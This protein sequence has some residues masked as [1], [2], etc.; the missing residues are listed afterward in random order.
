LFSEEIFVFTPKG[1]IKKLPKDATALDF[2]FEIHTEVGS[3]CIG[4]KVNSKLVPLSHQLNRGDQIEIITSNKQKPTKGWLDF[5]VTG[6]ARTKIK[7]VLKEEKRKKAADGKEIL[8]RKFRGWKLPLNTENMRILCLHFGIMSEQDF[9]VL[10]AKDRMPKSP[11]SYKE[12]IARHKERKDPIKK[13]NE[14]PPDSN[15]KVG[16]LIIGEDDSLDLEYSFAKCCSPIPGD[17]VMGFITVGDGIKIHRTNCKNAERL[18]SNYGYRIIKAR[19][20]GFPLID[21]SFSAGLEITGIDSV[22][23]VS[24]VTDII[25]KELQVNMEAVSFKAKDG[26]FIGNLVLEI[27][28]TQHLEGLI[29]KIKSIDKHIEVNRT[30]LS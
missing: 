10:V 12:I 26:T 9:Y 1:D 17:D 6:K 7:Q 3:K 24:K 16:D 27:D 8:L 25:S 18:M 29:R 28:S 21:H 30:D 14:R 2:A 4:A 22:G 5:V 23:L 20:A 15:K 11:I 19:W 13:I